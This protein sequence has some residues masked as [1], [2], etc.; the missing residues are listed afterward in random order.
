MPVQQ[1]IFTPGAALAVTGIDCVVPRPAG[2]R[3]ASGPGAQPT[4][5]PA[6]RYAQV[7]AALPGGVIVLDGDGRISAFNAAAASLAGPLRAG[8]SWREVVARSIA[9]RWDDGH[10][11]SL[12][13]GRRV[14][15]ATQ[16]LDDPPGQLV[17][18]ADVTET[19]RLQ[20]DLARYKRLAA[21]GELAAALAHQVRTPLATAVLYTGM[22]ARADL[23]AARRVDCADRVLD[24]LRHLERLVE[25]MLLYARCGSFDREPLAVTDLLAALVRAAEPDT[26]A[27][28][29]HLVTGGAPPGLRIGA[30]R[31]ALVSALHNL[32]ANA[33]QAGATRLAIAARGDGDWL[34]LT[35]EDDG[36]G[37]PGTDPESIFAP[38]VSGRPGGSGLGLA[39]VRAIVGAHGGDIRLASRA[40]C[41][42]CFLV[43][44]PLAPRD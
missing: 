31:D 40:G 4:P 12:A 24:R 44:L 29:F 21:E 11:V 25:D 26:R 27:A 10:D 20:D 7:F 38:F 15:I 16:A 30:N 34:E 42:A 13:N 35:F 23:D 41:G 1:R 33:R 5:P 36:P 18:L 8:E 14:N 22:L 17:L 39:V 3:P 6:Q 2:R 43:R 28:G 9:P 32:I 19:R 37:V